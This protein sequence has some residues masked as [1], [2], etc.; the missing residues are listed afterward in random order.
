MNYFV[1]IILCSNFTLEIN[2]GCQTT[3]FIPMMTTLC[4]RMFAMM[5]VSVVCV[6]AHAQ[7]SLGVAFHADVVSRYVWRG[8]D[9]GQGASVQPTLE[10]NYGGFSLGAWASTSIAKVTD[11]DEVDLYVSYATDHFSATL[12]DYYWNGGAADYSDYKNDHYF[13][14]G[15]NYT[16]SDNVPLSLSWNTIL[17]GGKSWEMDEDDDRMFS[18]YFNVSYGFDVHGVSLTPAIGINPWK[19]QYD[20]GFS[21]MDITLTAAKDFQI[22]DKWTLPVQAQFIVS[23][24]TEKAYLVVGVTF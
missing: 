4:K 18:S 13:E 15:L 11:V 10:L 23:P 5:F 1:F 17:F 6:L 19:S 16:V 14:L 12:T 2:N 24:A 8:M 22:T 20:D 3:R 7:D 9:Q 21:V